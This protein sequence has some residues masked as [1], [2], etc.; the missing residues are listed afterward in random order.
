ML[1]AIR[2]QHQELLPGQ[3]ILR[4]RYSPVTYTDVTLGC[5]PANIDATLGSATA[6]DGCGAVT[7]TSS[8]A[9]SVLTDA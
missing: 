7:I 9:A 2:L 5:N 3:K 6:T 4:H 8:D 1:V